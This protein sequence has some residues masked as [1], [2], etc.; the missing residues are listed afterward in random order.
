MVPAIWLRRTL[1]LTIFIAFVGSVLFLHGR[2]HQIQQDANVL[3]IPDPVPNPVPKPPIDKPPISYKPTPTYSPPPVRDPFPLLAT[4]TPPPIPKWNQPGEN[5]HKTYG[6]NEG[7]ALLIGFTRSWPILLQAVVS[8]ITA[9]WPPAQIHIVENTGVQRANS[10]GKL[11]LQNPF[12]LNHTTLRTLGVNVIQTPTLLS[13]SQLQNFYISVAHA[14]NWPWYFWTHQDTLALSFED[15]MDGVTP[16]YDQP[17][18]KTLYELALMALNET[19]TTDPRWGSRFFAYDH[20]AL[21]NRD[22]YDDVGGWDSMIPYYI[23]D[24]DM[25]TRLAMAGWSTKDYTVGVLTDIATSFENLLVLYRDPS[26][27]PTFVDPNPPAPSSE[28]D[29]DHSL[30]ERESHQASGNQT[31]PISQRTP[32]EYWRS[33]NKVGDDML[34]YKN[35]ARGRNTWQLGQQGGRGEPYYYPN[36]GLAEAMEV[37]T[38]AG[39]EVYRRKW[40]HRDCDL[41]PGTRLKL[42]DQWMVE[43]DW[44]D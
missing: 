37:L 40:G 8:Y 17:G 36:V 38:E 19:V 42:E 34:H 14:E 6:F 12:Y 2:K 43:R 24:C 31:A 20:L 11:T 22:A 21:V 3:K 30:A 15:G 5:L 7:P 23:T 16:A 27:V 32:I 44:Q 4:S 13:F 29:L 9:G 35:G 10:K 28:P 39:K 33:L 18:Y 25:Y 26:F 41:I 1:Q